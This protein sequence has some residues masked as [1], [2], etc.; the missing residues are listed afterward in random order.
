MFKYS[1]YLIFLVFFFSV[2]IIIAYKSYYSDK[3]KIIRILSKLPIKQIGNFKNDEFIRLSGSTV[4]LDTPLKAPISKK[5]CIFYKIKIEELITKGKNSRWKVL[6]NDEKTQDFLLEKNGDFAI[7]RPKQ[8]PNNYLS[9]L[10]VVKKT[11]A[12]KET[13]ELKAL[14]KSYNINYN[15]VGNNKSI[16]YSEALI[17]TNKQISV[18]GIAKWFHLQKLIKGY[19]YSKITELTSSSTQ[20][21]IITDLPNIP[22]KKR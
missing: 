5:E 21:L 8:N 22:S 10:N 1:N 11:K 9:Y 13:P 2:L 19:S 7:I 12:F 3:Q 6:I 4:S 17:E 20:K 14:L 18:A 16:R 15:F